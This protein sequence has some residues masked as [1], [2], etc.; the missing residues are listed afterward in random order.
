MVKKAKPTEDVSADH[1]VDTPPPAPP[2]NRT[3]WPLVI[4]IILAVTLPLV[5][6]GVNRVRELRSKT[7]TLPIGSVHI[8]PEIILTDLKGENVYLSTLAFD[9]AGSPVWSGVRYQ[10]GIS[11]TNSIG[12]L[13]PNSNEKL[14]TFE[15]SATNRGSGD[16]WVKAYDTNGQT[17]IGSIPVYV[18]VTPTPTPTVLPT[19]TPVPNLTVTAPNGGETLLVGQRYPITWTSTHNFSRI[20]IYYLSV[21]GYSAGIATYVPDTGTYDWTV[22]V[23]QVP[24]DTQFKIGM[25]GTSGTTTVFEKSDNYF[26]VV[27]PI[28]TPTPTPTPAPTPTSTPSP[29]PSP[30]ATIKPTPTS[31]PQPTLKPPVKPTIKPPPPSPRP[32]PTPRPKP[33]WWRRW[34][35]WLPIAF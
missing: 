6:W 26:T 5:V 19:P 32:R 13:W 17:V 34:F 2:K 9:T 35:P 25:V 24:S 16:I 11:T 30:T 3:N 8:N 31:T 10:W 14:A 33:P 18:G 1:S 21:A 28:P 22:D 15:P 23:S 7:T 4:A 29:L 20:D 27:T 12:I